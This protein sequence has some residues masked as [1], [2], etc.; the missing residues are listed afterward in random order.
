MKTLVLCLA[1]LAAAPGMA[2]ESQAVESQPDPE[3]GALDKT[4]P[5]ESGLADGDGN[6]VAPARIVTRLGSAEDCL[7]P[8]IINRIDGLPLHLPMR[9]F[10]I[11]PGKHSLNGL[12]VM[13][14]T[15]C[16]VDPRSGF[17]Q[18]PDL[19]VEIESGKTYYLGFDH[20]SRDMSDWRLVVWKVE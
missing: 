19:V 2:M 5:D 14:T 9:G 16:P 4:D 20:R 12:A 1:I 18:L 10:P 15:Y 17:G 11:E 13:D 6:V 8:M 7:A 3:V